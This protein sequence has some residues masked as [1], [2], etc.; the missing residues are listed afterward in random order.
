MGLGYWAYFAGKYL[1]DMGITDDITVL[2][3]FPIHASLHIWGSD[4]GFKKIMFRMN[5]MAVVH[6]VNTM[7]SK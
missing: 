1:F 7:T 5:N 6:I 2:E 4:L 3:L